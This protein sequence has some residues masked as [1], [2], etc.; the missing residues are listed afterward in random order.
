VYD[1]E[2]FEANGEKLIST[3]Y[4][5]LL[6][7]LM[8]TNW[9]RRTSLK[10]FEMD[11]DFTLQKGS[12]RHLKWHRRLGV[13]LP[14]SLSQTRSPAQAAAPGPGARRKPPAGPTARVPL[15]GGGA[16]WVMSDESGHGFLSKTED[17]STRCGK[18]GACHGQIHDKQKE[19]YTGR[20][21]NSKRRGN[22]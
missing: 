20:N 15:R 7:L 12:R 4:A 17:G 2:I 5:Y 3:S 11:S 9:K 21:I 10:C 16:I 13:R 18:E 14:T 19:R 6:L 22:C 1:V 8:W